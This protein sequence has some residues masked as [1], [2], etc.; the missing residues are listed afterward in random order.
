MC[1]YVLIVH[2]ITDVVS[3]LLNDAYSADYRLNAAGKTD[4]RVKHMNEIISGIRVVKMY[5][6]EY[7][8]HQLIGSLRRCV[9]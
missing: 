1:C 8:F 6:W 9:H 7:A 4:K 2:R 5:G 3:K